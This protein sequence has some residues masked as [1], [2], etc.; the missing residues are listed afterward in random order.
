ML[1][2]R[3]VAGQQRLPEHR[4]VGAVSQ[5]PQRYGEFVEPGS[6]AAVVEVD[7]PDTA[8]V[9]QRI[10]EVQVGVNETDSANLGHDLGQLHLN[11]FEPGADLPR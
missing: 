11:R 4:V 8:A 6:G 2:L 5:F 3:S 9:E 10:A 1:P 7:Q